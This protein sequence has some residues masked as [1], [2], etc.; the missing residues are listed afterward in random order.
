SCGVPISSGGWSG[1]KRSMTT[2]AQPSPGA[3][4]TTAP[5]RQVYAG[6]AG[7]RLA[8]ALSWFWFVHGH[9]T[10][11][12]RWLEQGLAAGPGGPTSARAAGLSGA[13]LLAWAQGDYGP[14]GAFFDESLTQFRNLAEPPGI[15][16]ALGGLGLV[17]HY[18]GDH[19]RAARRFEEA[20]AL[21]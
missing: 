5:G 1:S 13:G 3:R 7:L 19:E 20:L 15:A 12:R 8:T 11:G 17:A 2:C 16:V 14:A 18:V 4:R 9:L 6:Q 21:F 10:E